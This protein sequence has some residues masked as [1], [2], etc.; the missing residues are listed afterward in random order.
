MIAL[1]GVV[2][3]G[4]L[5]FVVSDRAFE[6]RPARGGTLTEAVVGG[7]LSLSPLFAS[8]PA[9]LD[10]VRLVF[11]GLTRIN[12][13]GDFVPDLAASW[14]V[15]PDGTIYLFRLRP[16]VF[17]HDGV[18]VTSADVVYT[19]QMAAD[20]LVKI[21]TGRLAKAWENVTVNALDRLTVQITMTEASPAFLEGTTLGLLPQHLLADV[22]P[23]GLSEHRFSDTPIGSGPY[24]FV[25]S[26]VP[27]LTVRLQRFEEYK[28]PDGKMPLLDGIEFRLFATTEQALRALGERSVQAMGGVPAAQLGRW[29]EAAREYT[30]FRNAY[31]L[32]YLNGANVLFGD[33]AVREALSLAT[34]RAGVVSDPEL[35][36]GQGTVA[37]GP[38]P[39][40]SW[41]F[42][43]TLAA[44]AF[45]LDQARQR[46]D[47]ANWLD[48]DEDGIRDKDGKP[49]KFTLVTS[50]D[51]LQ[52]GIAHKLVADWRSLAISVTLQSL[53]PQTMRGYLTNR[54]YEALLFRWDSLQPAYDPD[55]F[56][57]WHSTQP[58]NFSGYSSLKLD[59]ILIQGRQLSPLARDLR[60]PIYSAFAQAFAAERPALM[61][62]HPAYTYVVVDPNLGGVQLP[63]L[64]VEPADRFT[65]IAGWYARTERLI[66]GR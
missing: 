11:S 2:L 29:G 28:T 38:F 3:V 13:V 14:E 62:Y 18:E 33:P 48:S 23:A 9:E 6:D 53:D 12:V 43:P 58:L 45:S 65:G 20:P 41:A 19:A 7:P 24:R 8:Q 15:S 57:E 55:P 5:L 44:P 26:S 66:R 32:V 54:T 25:E 40:G 10:V 51:P 16:G 31:T 36:N 17:W 37:T 47:A 34:N 64:M 63:G 50:D 42:D 59:E 49:L 60:K 61:L 27:G 56:L 4:L 1:G 35:V 52:S 22:P 39:P 30:A 46:L 21:S